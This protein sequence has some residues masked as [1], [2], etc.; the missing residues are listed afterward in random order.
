MWQSGLRALVRLYLSSF[1]LRD[2]KGRIYAALN[3]KLLPAERFVTIPI[4]YGF[5][6]KLDLSEPAQRKIYF[7][8]DYDERHE[9]TLLRQILL[10]GDIFWDIGA[11]IG[12]YTLTASP[13]V[14][15]QG[16]VVAFEPASHAW[17]SLTANLSLNPSD[18]VQPVQI[19][20][21]DGSGQAVL[22]RR[23]D[24]ADGGASLISRDDYHGDSEVV[25]TL[26]LDQFLAQSG[27]PPP[28][29]MKIDVEG[30][31]GNV[32]TGGKNILQSGQPPL[33]LIEMNDPDRIGKILRQAGY[34][35]AYL[36]RRRWYPAHS[37]TEVKSRNML[38]F[39]PDS[40]LHRERL[41]LTNFCA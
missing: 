11:N 40:P 22:Y 12:F 37:L 20:L 9:I 3:E 1:P 34:Q 18:N 16:R 24:F 39:R 29:F 27:S 32:L 38:W 26:S 8:G 17:Q 35:G 23:A 30:L 7:F 33:I 41:A 21:S 10:P 19:A 28:T 13:L 4:R 15:P 25:T 2:G 14:R 6:L 36:H 5:R 31:E